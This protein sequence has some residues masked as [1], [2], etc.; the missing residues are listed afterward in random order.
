MTERVS[1][2]V[3]EL[4]ERL[5]ELYGPRL[6]RVVL[7]GSQAR[8]DATPESDVDVLV[9]LH[10]DVRPVEEI[11]RTGRM[12]SEASLH[13]GLDVAVS[14]ISAERFHS[15]ETPFVLNVRREGVAV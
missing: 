11:R 3:A 13:T 5:E 2:L 14:F 7:F 12:V 9:V 4:R 6:E 10:G 8:G 15:E 1:T